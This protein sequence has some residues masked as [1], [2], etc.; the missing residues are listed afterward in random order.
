MKTVVADHWAGAD[1][2]EPRIR[3]ILDAKLIRRETGPYRALSDD[4]VISGLERLLR[5]NGVTDFRIENLGRMPGGASKEQFWFTLVTGGKSERLVLRIDPLESIVETCRLREAELL[6]AMQ[7][8]LPLPAVRFVDGTG[9]YLGQPGTVTTFVSGVSKPPA[10]KNVVSG[11]GT[12]FSQEWRDRLV[13]AFVDHLARI[14][15]FDW[16]Q[17]ELPHFQ[18][19]AADSQ[20]AALWQVNW[21][22]KVWRD[23]LTHPYPMLTLAERWMRERLPHC[24]ELVLLHG[25]YRTS[26]FMFDPET[27]KFT[28]VLDWELAHIGDFHEDLGWSIQRLFAGPPENGQTYI[29]GLLTREDFLTRYEAATG[30]T[31]NRKTLAFYEVLNAYKTA[32]MNLGSGEGAALRQNNHQDV[33]L[34]LLA[35]VGHTFITDIVRIIADEKHL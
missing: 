10:N 19:P 20:Q 25:D 35:A 1:A 6:T 15:G 17:A 22:T 4:T 31:V 28:A 33:L 9:N 16:R 12:S 34:T 18:A 14:H 5:G 26:N 11:V 23:D 32:V 3:E 2:L 7:G 24:D 30:R 13:P 8:Y 29:C 27:A 21:W